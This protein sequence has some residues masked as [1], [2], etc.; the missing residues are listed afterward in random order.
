M[1]QEGGDKGERQWDWKDLL[2][3]LND[4]CKVEYVNYTK[5]PPS[6]GFLGYSYSFLV[7]NILFMRLPFNSMVITYRDVLLAGGII[8]TLNADD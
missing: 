3:Q 2:A 4:S 6:P 1:V 7:I 5:S 8:T